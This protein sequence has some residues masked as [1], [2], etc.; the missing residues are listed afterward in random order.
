MKNLTNIKQLKLASKSSWTRPEQILDSGLS[1]I[2]KNIK[3]IIN[4]QIQLLDIIP[5]GTG[6]C[7]LK[8][9][10]LRPEAGNTSRKKSRESF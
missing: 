5:S 3:M 1:N 8:A 4:G 10:T 7:L 9:P 2:T 6:R